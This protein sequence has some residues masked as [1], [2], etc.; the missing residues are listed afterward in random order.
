[1]S[2]KQPGYILHADPLWLAHHARYSVG[3]RVAY[4]R[5]AGAPMKNVVSG[6]VLFFLPTL[7]PPKRIV[8]R[9]FF[10]KFEILPVREAWEQYGLALGATSYDAW[11]ELAERIESVRDRHEIGLIVGENFRHYPSPIGL[12]D[13]GVREVDNA[14]KGWSV[15][16]GDIERLTK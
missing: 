1:M 13:V 5:G 7:D 4:C 2:D 14:P 6:G 8:A 3:G 11:R 15:G 10:S 12:A 9:A 16:A